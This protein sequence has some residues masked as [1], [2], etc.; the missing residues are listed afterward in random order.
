MCQQ[1]EK[2]T[3]ELQTSRLYKTHSSVARQM[4]YKCMSGKIDGARDML[5]VVND[6]F[7]RIIDFIADFG[8]EFGREISY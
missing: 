4:S 6:V 5:L 7:C 8:C 3:G 2:H 1:T